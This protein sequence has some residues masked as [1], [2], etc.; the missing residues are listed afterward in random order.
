MLAQAF[1]PTPSGALSSGRVRV[2]AAQLGDACLGA[3]EQGEC[4]G[5][6]GSDVRAPRGPTV[7][8]LGG[9]HHVRM[10]TRHRARRRAEQA[11][12]RKVRSL[13]AAGDQLEDVIH[14]AVLAL[15]EE[16]QKALWEALYRDGAEAML[17]WDRL[18]GRDVPSDA[19]T[20]ASWARLEALLRQSLRSQ[21]H[22][23]KEGK[24]PGAAA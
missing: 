16:D 23:D 11:A 24:R 20:A 22:G 10:K 19:E 13:S 21:G 14:R 1:G 7:V 17:V 15:L 18:R 6:T 8:R 4:A 3:A 2:S 9:A 5:R 12:L